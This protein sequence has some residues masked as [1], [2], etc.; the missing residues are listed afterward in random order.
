MSITATDGNTVDIYQ[1]NIYSIQTDEMQ[2]SQRYA[3]ERAIKE[4]GGVQIFES[5][6]KIDRS[7]VEL[8][9]TDIVGMTSIGFTP[10]I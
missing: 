9:K 4:V 8:G 5:K 7:I 3:T 6:C 2:K 1:F 10:E